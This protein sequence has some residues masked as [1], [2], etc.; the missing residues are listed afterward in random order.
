M[1]FYKAYSTYLFFSTPSAHPYS[2]QQKSPSYIKH[3]IYTALVFAGLYDYFQVPKHI[4]L[5]AVVLA[6]LYSL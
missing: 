4:A 1:L 5:A 6:N 3:L 2:R